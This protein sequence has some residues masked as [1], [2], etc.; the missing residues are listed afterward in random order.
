MVRL[1]MAPEQR[2]STLCDTLACD[3]GEPYTWSDVKWAPDGKSLALA[4]TSR[5]RQHETFRIADAET[6]DVRTAFE[7]T[8]KD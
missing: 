1:K 8:S 6:G 7:F 2:L 5:N 3:N 4:E